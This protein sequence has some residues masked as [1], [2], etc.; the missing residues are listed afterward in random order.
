MQPLKPVLLVENFPSSN[1]WTSATESHAAVLNQEIEIASL[2]YLQQ[3]QKR[4][5]ISHVN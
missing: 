1:I 2:E 5:C 3:R 4:K